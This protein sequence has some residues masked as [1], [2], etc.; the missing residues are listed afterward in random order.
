[1]VALNILTMPADFPMATDLAPTAIA[2][3]VACVCSIY[4]MASD[5]YSSPNPTTRKSEAR[6]EYYCLRML[7]VVGQTAGGKVAMLSGANKR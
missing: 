5:Q 2:D 1:M 3:A 7:E 6:A 4:E